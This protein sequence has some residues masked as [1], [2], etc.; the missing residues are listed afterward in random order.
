MSAL[1]ALLS[2]SDYF[3]ACALPCPGFSA[4]ERAK[5]DDTE[6]ISS[7]IAALAEIRD[8]V[9][10]IFSENAEVLSR[11][12]ELAAYLS[13]GKIAESLTE[14]LLRFDE[15]YGELKRER[16]LLDYND[17]EHIALE[18]LSVPAVAEEIKQKYRH[19]FVDEYQDVNPVQERILSAVGGENVFLVGDIKQSIYGFRGSKSVFFAEKQSRFEAEEGASSL[20]L[21]RN[22][23]SADAVLEAVN[24]QFLLAMTKENSDVDYAGGSFMERGGRYASDSG[25]VQIHILSK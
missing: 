17:L 9:K 12:E 1:S 24:A 4:K 22:F 8:K 7:H 10:G 3:S 2:A 25:R 15:K 18:L 16:G 14:Y 13:S 11:E 19:V 20:Y 6:E 23:R 21:T 5:K